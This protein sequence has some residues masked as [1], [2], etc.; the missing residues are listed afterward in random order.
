MRERRAMFFWLCCVL[1]GSSVVAADID[2]AVETEGDTIINQDTLLAPDGVASDEKQLH[3]FHDPGEPVVAVE[4]EMKIREQ[5]QSYKDYAKTH[6]GLTYGISY[7]I[8]YQGASDSFGADHAAGG[9]FQFIS[10]WTPVWRDTGHPGTFTFKVENRHRFSDVSLQRFHNDL[11][12]AASTAFSYSDFGWGVLELNYKQEFFDQRFAVQFGEIQPITYLD[13]Y[14]LVS[15]QSA[16][17]NQSFSYNPT[18]AIP[19]A[20]L[21]AV[22][23][24]RLWNQVYF[25]ASATDANA[26]NATFG[27]DT[28]VDYNEFFTHLELGWDF[29]GTEWTQDNVHVTLW[30]VDDRSA[31]GK[32]E[33]WG[34]AFSFAHEFG[35]WVPYLRGGYSEDGGVHFERMVSAGFG[36]KFDGRKGL[37]GFGS[38]WGQTPRPEPHDQFTTEVFWRIQVTQTFE[39]TPDLQMVFQPAYNPNADVVAIAG[40]RGRFKF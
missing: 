8:V 3:E 12:I 39:L 40:V 11:G 24:G 36:Y 30:H 29:D 21:G 23:G 6:F 17:L 16:F 38:S 2:R 13:R 22:V 7:S 25:T 15:P 27:W 1:P 37:V 32:P 10:R 31:A 5:W 14:P 18:I 19:A 4:P 26:S 33:G 9:R 28:M 34:V 35:R 20:G